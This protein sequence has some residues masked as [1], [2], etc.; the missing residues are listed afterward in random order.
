MNA[1]TCAIFAAAHLACCM[2]FSAHA[3]SGPTFY[4]VSSEPSRCENSDGAA[5][6]VTA[7]CPAGTVVWGGGILGDQSKME[8]SY[9]STGEQW[10]VGFRG[11]FHEYGAAAHATAQAFAICGPRP[12][13]FM[14]NFGSVETCSTDGASCST[15]AQCSSPNMTLL[16]GGILGT[17]SQVESSVPQPSP[18]PPIWVVSWFPD[19]EDIPSALGHGWPIVTCVSSPPAGFQY[20]YGD[21]QF[22]DFSGESCEATAECPAG[23]VVVGGGFE[24]NQ[25]K[26][27]TMAPVGPTT[28]LVRWYPATT[29]FGSGALGFGEAIAT[30]ASGTLSDQIFAS[31]FDE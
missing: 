20:A 17:E 7:V 2:P 28:W 30:C 8:S 26:I 19:D 22:C 11:A 6:Y 18:A 29:E 10:S 14:Q 4:R 9:P 24:G 15:A 23:T 16:A 25:S 1:K 27:E 12:V 3:G 5:C 21:G 31:G 13:G